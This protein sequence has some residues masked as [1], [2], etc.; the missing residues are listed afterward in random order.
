LPNLRGE[1][2]AHVDA[3]DLAGNAGPLNGRLDGVA[4]RS[5]RDIG[6]RPC[7]APIGVRA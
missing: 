1:H 7:I 3:V 4:P 2:A 5:V 6:Q